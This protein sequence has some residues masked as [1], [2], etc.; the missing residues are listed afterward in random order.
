MQ[1][2][3]GIL[4]FAAGIV[5]GAMNVIAGGGSLI[6]MPLLI[7][8][9]FAPITANGTDRV[10]VFAQAIAATG[11]FHRLGVV[12]WPKIARDA[13]PVAIGTLLGSLWGTSWSDDTF[14]Q[15]LGWITLGAGGLVA[16]GLTNR[17]SARNTAQAPAGESADG[18]PAA[19]DGGA[20]PGAGDASGPDGDGD[21][22]G[23]GGALGDPPGVRAG[24]DGLG[25]RIAVFV[26][27]LGVGVYAGSVLAGLGYVQLLV[28]TGVAGYTLKAANILK[29][30]LLL[31]VATI[32]LAV[33]AAHG[34]VDWL[35]GGALASGQALGAWLAAGHATRASEGRIRWALTAVLA[36]TALRL[37][38][39]T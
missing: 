25:R 2:G 26:G 9:G 15:A 3:T 33:F 38:T 7:F 29:S 6:T 28:L 4:L 30:L 11:R 39:A 13:L 1:L 20:A 34:R 37:L 22:D 18:G 23:D 24:R 14:R 32:G 16:S 21:G 35:A 10:A 5:A 36:L 19:E 8:L 27:L 31:P 12:D 17:A